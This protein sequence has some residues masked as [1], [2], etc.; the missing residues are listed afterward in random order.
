MR[1]QIMSGM[2]QVF[3]PPVFALTAAVVLLSMEVTWAA[4][5]S[6]DGPG[7]AADS[8]LL[9]RDFGIVGLMLI[10]GMHRVL[11]FHPLFNSEYLKWLKNSPWK[12]GMP[13][14]IG[15]VHP[16]WADA[17]VIGVLASLLTDSR[18]L[19]D[20]SL[21][22]PDAISAIL[23]CLLSHGTTVAIIVWLTRP[24]PP[25]WIS[26][27]LLAA[28]IQLSAW[29]PATA[30]PCLLA[31]WL[32]ALAGLSSSW[33]LFPWDETTVWG[34]RIKTRW[35]S[36]KTRSG[37]TIDDQSSPEKLPPSELGWPFSSLSPWVPT[38]SISTG[39]RMMTSAM[40]GWWLHAFLIHVRDES[41]LQGA[42]IMLLIYGTMFLMAFRIALV[43]GNHAS[44]INPLGRLLTLRWII[45]GYDQI[46]VAPIL[47]GVV[48][49][50]LML[51]GRLWFPVPLHIL[52]PVAAVL[53][54]W[55]FLLVGPDPNNWKL[56]APARVFAG[57][58]NT[59]S[60]DQLT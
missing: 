31:G 10:Y 35:T 26:L 25:A 45:P 41:V 16:L 13:L 36:M 28:G 42:T 9:A 37:G 60:F 14:P 46:I 27:F 53:T 56:T 52:T 33:K 5:S 1:I 44:P 39:E 20:P 3:P 7:E 29:F 49:L 21:K 4:I 55:T 54:L 57:K 24:R 30:V 47:V 2:R 38:R 18:T 48:P 11:S 17:V 23:T 15:A 59:K 50:V 43:G 19:F 40:A 8:A 12:R 6:I 34:S 51:A 32:V 22:R 58:P